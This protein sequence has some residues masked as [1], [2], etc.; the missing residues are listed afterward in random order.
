VLRRDRLGGPP[1]NGC[2]TIMTIVTV[3]GGG[4]PCLGPCYGASRIVADLAEGRRHV[5]RMP[6]QYGPG[7]LRMG[8][9]VLYAPAAGLRAGSTG[10]RW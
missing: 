8:R 6:Y 7:S 2:G 9:S 3:A 1:A 4:Q 10:G 5:G